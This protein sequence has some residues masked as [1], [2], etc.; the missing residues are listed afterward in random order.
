MQNKKKSAFSFKELLFAYLAISKV[1]Y[2]LNTIAE[3]QQD[4]LGAVWHRVLDRLLTQDILTIWILVAMFLIEHYIDTHPSIS[5]GA[6][7][8][9]LV[10]S[11]GYV[12]YIISLI[13][14]I[15]ILGMIIDTQ[16]NN[17]VDFIVS[18][19]IV[20]AVACLVLYIKEHIKKK[21]AEVHSP[22]VNSDE[23]S[24]SLLT[25]LWERGVLTQDEYDNKK[26]E[27]AS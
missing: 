20:Y 17:W 6:V 26:A 2:W 19:S 23:D 11:I 4:E 3:I 21:E 18:Y 22:L 16:I 24:L 12:F 9:I 27:L 5:K 25:T 15:L 8:N 7:K 10:Y 1:T 13:A 14:Y